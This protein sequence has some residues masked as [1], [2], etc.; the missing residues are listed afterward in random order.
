MGGRGRLSIG[1]IKLVRGCGGVRCPLRISFF[2]ACNQPAFPS[3]FSSHS[4]QDMLLRNRSRYHELL[5][6]VMVKQV[7]LLRNRLKRLPR[8]RC[9]CYVVQ[10]AEVFEQDALEDPVSLK[11]EAQVSLGGR[12]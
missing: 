6:A 8:L 3:S 5:M 9:L 11:T 10:V 12:G 4:N 1:V 2:L 7:G